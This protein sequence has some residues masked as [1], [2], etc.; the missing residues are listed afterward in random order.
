MNGS[1]GRGP[2]YRRWILANAI[3]EGLGLGGTFVIGLIIAPHVDDSQG[4]AAILAGAAAAIGLGVLLEGVLVG[5]A[6]G[7][8]LCAAL[9]PLRRSTWI[10]ATSAGAGLAWVLGMVPSTVIALVESTSPTSP[11]P[12]VTGAGTGTGTV[13]EPSALVIY[14]LAALL[15]CVAGPILGGIQARALGRHVP[16]A[17]RWVWANARAWAVG[18]VVIFV[19]MDVLPW[20]SGGVALWAGLVLVSSIAGA[21]VGA[22]HGLTLER[23]VREARAT[24]GGVGGYMVAS[25]VSRESARPVSE[26]SVAADR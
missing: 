25:R 12:A 17:S 8:V 10:R 5:W 23:L 15:G 16:R 4:V 6:Q 1:L 11:S 7:R 14:A 13:T 2:I 3:A 9:P 19:G 24:S 22:I 26:S 21:V 18:M 20:A